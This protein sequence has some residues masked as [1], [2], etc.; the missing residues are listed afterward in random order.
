MRGHGGGRGAWAW[1][2][3][4]RRLVKLE[5]KVQ[6]KAALHGLGA[7]Q[8]VA[9]ARRTAWV[10]SIASDRRTE[11]LA[12][13]VHCPCTHRQREKGGVACTKRASV[14]PVGLSCAQLLLPRVVV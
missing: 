4:S 13:C 11:S 8:L 9:G 2:D 1:E 12:P 7:G 6:L 3:E 5:L 14:P 10:V